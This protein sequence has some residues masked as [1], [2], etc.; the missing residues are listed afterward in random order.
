MRGLVAAPTSSLLV[1]LAEAEV[2]EGVDCAEMKINKRYE[3]YFNIMTL[4]MIMKT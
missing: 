3:S 1:G 2:M 4:I